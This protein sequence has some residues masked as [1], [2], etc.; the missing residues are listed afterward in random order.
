M[1][2]RFLSCLAL[3]LSPCGYAA[4]AQTPPP[5]PIALPAAAP[6][7]AFPDIAAKIDAALA[8]PALRH[9]AV[10]ILVTSLKTGAVVYAHNA[11]LTLN[12]ASNEK[13]L[14]GSTALA[15]LG[16]DFAYHTTLYRTGTIG[17]D[18]T[19]TGH[20][21]LRGTGDPSLTS[22][23][24]ATLAKM[25]YAQG[26][27]YFSGS[28]FADATRF[29]EQ[30]IGLGWEWE[31]LS[32][33]YA[34]EVAALNCD[35]NVATVT[36][37]PALAAGKQPKVML[38][39]IPL[40]VSGFSLGFDGN[41]SLILHNF[42]MT[43]TQGREVR[44][45]RVLGHNAID[46]RG[47][48]APGSKPASA[49]I[50]IDDPALFA[51]FRLRAALR[52]AGIDRVP[53]NTAETAN[54]SIIAKTASVPANATVVGEKVSEPLSALLHHCW[55]ESDNLYAE[56]FLKTVGAEKG[57]GGSSRA[58]AAV[59]NDFLRKSNVDT[60]GVV[61]VD[62]SGLSRRDLV[63]PR[64][65]VGL[66]TAM[67]RM[68]PAARD[69]LLAALPIAGVDGTLRNR[70]KGTPAQGRVQAKTGSLS[71]V[72]ALS[73]FATAPRSGE[74]FAFSVLLNNYEGGATAAH[75]LQD[76]VAE[77]LCNR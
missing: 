62:G 43:E 48:I 13:L 3:V 7:S 52:L 71:A 76:Q 65:L 22:A 1:H 8:A 16:P 51:A 31:D 19:L 50:T 46:V 72:S 40:D 21:Y 75:A 27:R 33:D 38:D 24:L 67:D 35:E 17:A 37:T 70:M 11:D 55:K 15:R 77:V 66:L 23:D 69:V 5:A 10:G 41:S 60:G 56:A 2:C 26:V 12:P 30:H 4:R 49:V 29:D 36:V 74:R 42:A 73:G 59:V 14:T 20:L 68:P 64:A 61:Q 25:L 6:A 63:T 39:G 34:A 53:A 18:G 32:D 57:T 44:I 45:E 58:G 9:A 28:I 54:F 47:S